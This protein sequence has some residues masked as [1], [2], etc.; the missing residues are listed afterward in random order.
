LSP[1][2]E[3]RTK[4]R[5][6]QQL[7][8]N[9]ENVLVIQ[10][11]TKMPPSRASK[12]PVRPQLPPF[13]RRRDA[14]DTSL[15]KGV[16][17]TLAQQCKGDP[18]QTFIDNALFAFP[19]ARDRFTGRWE[20]LRE[21]DDVGCMHLVID[22]TRFVTE[23]EKAAELI[24]VLA[25]QGG[26]TDPVMHRFKHADCTTDVEDV[27]LVLA[28][29]AGILVVEDSRRVRASL[30]HSYSSSLKSERQ[31]RGS[32][33]S[34]SRGSRRP[35]EIHFDE[36]ASYSVDEINNHNRNLVGGD[37]GG[38]LG[39]AVLDTASFMFRRIAEKCTDAWMVHRRDMTLLSN[40]EIPT[41]ARCSAAL[42]VMSHCGLLLLRLACVADV[43]G[44]AGFVLCPIVNIANQV[45]VDISS[46][47]GVD[48]RQQD[49]FR[50]LLAIASNLA[51]LD[52]IDQIRAEGGGGG[53][54]VTRSGSRFL[55]DALFGRLSGAD[56]CQLMFATLEACKAGTHLDA[57]HMNANYEIMRD[58]V[59]LFIKSAGNGA[60]SPAHWDRDLAEDVALLG[61][62][63]VARLVKYREH[64]TTAVM[65]LSW[66][67]SQ[68]SATK[69]SRSSRMLRDRETVETFC[70]DG[71]CKKRPISARARSD[72]TA[73]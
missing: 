8:Q 73:L 5:L 34:G 20:L 13:R 61:K 15:W 28:G 60:N 19:G 38:N 7:F 22:I 59:R 21:C 45:L 25:T 3:D 39:I 1:P 44:I 31:S 6:Q 57:A 17:E 50:V 62:E 65:S 43:T 70:R 55:F 54:K 12:L 2:A 42:R 9:C 33:G 41:L 63:D 66:I 47:N 35:M 30:R 49:E 24:S 48:M 40:A 26:P 11:V 23:C 51:V 67:A 32:R 58:H 36:D 46:E 16:L 71:T 69:K 68:Y 10:Y 27:V 29:R 14:K 56:L 72:L 53:G 18:M 64:C 4:M 37:G 52:K